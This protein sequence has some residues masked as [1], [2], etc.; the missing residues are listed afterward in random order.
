MLVFLCTIR[1]EDNYDGLATVETLAEEFQGL[2]DI[3]TL[4]KCFEKLHNNGNEP[5]YLGKNYGSDDSYWLR[6]EGLEMIQ[7]LYPDITLP[8]ERKRF[9]LTPERYNR[10]SLKS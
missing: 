8:P 10:L 6:P 1:R 2:M 9:I 7:K 5:C 4:N 3:D